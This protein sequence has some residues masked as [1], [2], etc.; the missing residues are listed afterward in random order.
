MEYFKAD[1]ALLL[2]ADVFQHRRSS[3]ARARRCWPPRKQP[4]A[5][6]IGVLSH[7]M[8]PLHGSAASAG[9]DQEIKAILD[10]LPPAPASF[11]AD[12]NLLIVHGRLIVDV[13]PRVDGLLGQI[14][15]A[16][17]AAGCARCAICCAA[18]STAPRRGQNLPLA[19][20]RHREL[21]LLSYLSYLF[22]RLQLN[23]PGTCA[24]NADLQREMLRTPADGG[25]RPAQE[26]GAMRWR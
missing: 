8:L 2:V 11:R 13:L 6:E 5:A 26:R 10:R 22:A 7:P 14:V 19:A 20:V 4:L 16:P 24:A 3:A 25:S 23:A 9:V 18:T 15:E 1:N 21:L 12:L 17:T